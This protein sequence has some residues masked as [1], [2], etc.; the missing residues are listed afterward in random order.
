M[1]ASR[2]ERR[3]F[4]STS[5]LIVNCEIRLIAPVGGRVRGR[6]YSRMGMVLTDR[7]REVHRWYFIDKRTI[8]EIADWLHCSRHVAEKEVRD[9][10]IIFRSHGQDLPKF[11]RGRDK[12]APEMQFVGVI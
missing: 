3:F 2:A 12:A 8:S 7:Q 6:A 9:L 10:R 1:W 4:V 11:N 5:A